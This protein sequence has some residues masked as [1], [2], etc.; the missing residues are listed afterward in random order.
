MSYQDKNNNGMSQNSLAKEYN[1][2]R[3]TIQD[4]LNGK[5]WKKITIKQ[6]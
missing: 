4:I 5:T 3:R 6:K 2:S 1:V